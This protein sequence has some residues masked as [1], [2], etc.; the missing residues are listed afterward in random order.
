MDRRFIVSFFALPF[1]FTKINWPAVLSFVDVL[2]SAANRS[3]SIQNCW[4]VLDWLRGCSFFRVLDET[5]DQIMKQLH[6]T[7][8]PSRLF[9]YV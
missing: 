8:D 1:S 6:I 7:F 5:Q 3:A 9:A 2:E 4:T